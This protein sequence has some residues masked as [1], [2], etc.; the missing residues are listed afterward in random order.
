MSKSVFKIEID[1]KALSDFGDHAS[2]R[3]C[4][5]DSD[6]IKYV[7]EKAFGNGKVSVIRMG[8]V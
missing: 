3:L 7:L 6:Q 2:D 5:D 4:C 1:N 8:Q